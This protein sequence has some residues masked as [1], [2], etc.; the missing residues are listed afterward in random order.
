LFID[1]PASAFEASARFWAAATGREPNAE[2]PTEPPYVSLGYFHG[3]LAVE[4]QRTGEGTQPRVHLDIDTD[5]VEA[6]VRRLEALGA[7]RLEQHGDYWQMVDPGGVVFCV[8]PPHTPD[9]D[10][11]ATVWE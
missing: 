9:F 11:H 4:L 6:E 8:I 5:D 7:T 10:E 2:R 3:S 1:Q